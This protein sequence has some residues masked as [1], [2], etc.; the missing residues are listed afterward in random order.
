[1]MFI[2]ES[3]RGCSSDFYDAQPW[4]T[5][6]GRYINPLRISSGTL[7]EHRRI[8]V[9]VPLTLNGRKS[10]PSPVAR[11]TVKPERVVRAA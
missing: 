8:R 4:L 6:T 9:N 7:T 3:N 11:S 10:P 5:P 2:V 1:M